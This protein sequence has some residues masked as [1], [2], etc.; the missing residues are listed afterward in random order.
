MALVVVDAQNDFSEGGSLAVRGAIA[1]YRRLGVYVAGRANKYPVLVTTR[2]NHIDP[3]AHFSDQPDFVDSWPVHCVADTDGAEL[4]PEVQRS[5]DLFEKV[6]PH[7]VRIDVTKGEYSAAYS[8]FEGRTGTGRL[9]ADALR[10]AGVE[11][12][13]VCGVATDFCVR[14]TVLD[15]LREGFDVSVITDLVAAVSTE[16]GAKALDEMAAAGAVLV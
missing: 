13:H 15:G 11:E 7:A 16:G 2:D 10:D 1:A 4:H 9:L 5:L 14:A 8:G 6:N 3:G 12:L